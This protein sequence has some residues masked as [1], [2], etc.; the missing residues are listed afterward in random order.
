MA[1]VLSSSKQLNF[2]KPVDQRMRVP[3]TS[4][5]LMSRSCDPELAVVWFPTFK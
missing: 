2:S 4:A 1:L 5:G 3:C